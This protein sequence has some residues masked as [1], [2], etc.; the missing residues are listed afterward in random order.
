MQKIFSK[1]GI[2]FLVLF[3]VL[4]LVGMK[5]NFST[6]IGEE[7]QF[8]TIYQFFGPIAGGFLGIWGAAAVLGAQLIN[9]VLVGKEISILNLLRLLPMVFA[10]IY[11]S[12]NGV[13]GIKDKLGLALPIL[14]MLAFWFHPVG[15]QAWIYALFWVIPVIAKFLPENLVLRSLGATF[16]AHAVGAVLWI[17]TVPMTAEQ[18]LMLLPITAFERILFALGIAASYVVFVNILKAVDS[19]VDIKSII[20][21]DERY[22][23]WRA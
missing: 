14:A 18:W 10:A 8:L 4:A 19:V 1:K 13:R 21:I 17:W 15:Q 16:T 3:T 5:L 20:N 22:A 11:F 6:L 9:W 23:L 12:R 7:S 2:V